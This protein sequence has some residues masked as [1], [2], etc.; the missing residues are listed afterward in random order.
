MANPLV[1]ALFCLLRWLHLIAREPYW[2]YAAVVLGG[3]VVSIFA[4]ACLEHSN[5]RWSR[6]ALIAVNMGVIGVVA[7][8]TG[9]GSILSI[10]FL[11]GAA[12]SFQ[13][14]GSKAT[15]PCIT[16]T[17]VA[18]AIGQLAIA[19]HL[20]PTLIHQPLVH[21]VAGLSLVGAL[22]VIELLG[23]ATAAREVVE[24]ELR[25]SERRFKALVSNAA[26][27]IIVTDSHGVMQYVSPAFQRILGG[28]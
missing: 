17:A 6:D 11:F 5:R 10:G 20:A 1:L 24:A 8:S 22:L 21:G 2:L 4:A 26:D 23:Q 3:G 7:Y 25:Q 19:L 28:F 15:W 27:I 9:W 16:W 12:A 14:L 13:V 18:M